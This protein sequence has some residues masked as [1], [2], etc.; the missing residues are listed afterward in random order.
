MIRTFRGLF[1]FFYRLYLLW[2]CGDYFIQ[3]VTVII[4][5]RLCDCWLTSSDGNG[6]QKHNEQAET[7]SHSEA[8]D[9]R[10]CGNTM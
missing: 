5:I 3:A 10:F 9:F 2:K 6:R 8:V 1:P 7:S 4:E